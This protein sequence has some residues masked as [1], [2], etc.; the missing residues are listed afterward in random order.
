MVLSVFSST[1]VLLMPSSNPDDAWRHFHQEYGQAMVAW[2]T[3]ESELATLFS[4][5]TKIPPAMAVKIY[6]ASRSFNG[7]LDVFKE[8]ISVAPVSPEAKSFARLVAKKSQKYAE[9]RNKFAHDQPLLRQ[10]GLPATFDIVMVDGKGQFQADELKKQ[11]VDAGVPVSEITHAAACFRQLAD[12][13]SQYWIQFRAQVSPTRQSA[14]HEILH[15]RL[16]TL[17]TLPRKEGQS[18]QSAKPKRRRGPSLE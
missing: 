6:Y 8:G 3:L 16:A 7:R 4:F 18:P 12:L 2:Q 10:Q 15:E 17:P 9:Y 13:V 14:W 11:Y 1:S 5:L